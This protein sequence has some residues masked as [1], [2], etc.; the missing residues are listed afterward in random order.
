[1]KAVIPAFLAGV[2]TFF[3][4]CLLPLIPAYIS[5][6][7]AQGKK[8]ISSILFIAG[9]TVV[10][11]LMGAGAGQIGSFLMTYYKILKYIAGS[12]LFFFGLLFA[13]AFEYRI[14]ANLIKAATALLGL[15]FATGILDLSYIYLFSPLLLTLF[16]FYIGAPKFLTRN[17]RLNLRGSSFTLGISFAVGWTPCTG[18]LLGSVI[19]LAMQ[20][21]TPLKGIFILLIYSLGLALPFLLTAVMFKL[22]SEKIKQF[23]KH[24]PLIEKIG[25]IFLSLFGLY[26]IFF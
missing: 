10:Y 8:L 16:L 13:N 4:P 14:T 26:I 5:F 15:L 3:S 25:G 24:L 20:S 22:A 12:L 21:G 18:P 2:S 6:L 19:I 9:F 1:M 23:Q 17:V 11:M 7:A